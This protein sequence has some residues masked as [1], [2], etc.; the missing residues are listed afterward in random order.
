MSGG[1]GDHQSHAFQST[2]APQG[3]CTLVYI[4]RLL[5]EYTHRTAVHILLQQNEAVSH[6]SRD[7][8]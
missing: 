5:Y 1:G 3:G 7:L 4:T 6:F 2:D 8:R